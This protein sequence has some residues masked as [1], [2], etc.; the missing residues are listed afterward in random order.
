MR[1]IKTSVTLE[2]ATLRQLHR[3]AREEDRSVSNL[4]ECFL[5]S[6][7]KERAKGNKR[8]GRTVRL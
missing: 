2:K 1:R 7:L 8:P 3:I 6:C 4:I 5:R